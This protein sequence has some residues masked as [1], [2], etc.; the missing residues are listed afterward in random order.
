MFLSGLVVATFCYMQFFP[1]PYSNDGNTPIS[2]IIITSSK[3]NVVYIFDLS[4]VLIL[5]STQLD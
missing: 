5:H 2:L 3:T 1:A 4:K